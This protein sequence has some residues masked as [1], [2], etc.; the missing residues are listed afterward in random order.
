LFS[1][2]KKKRCL[3][4]KKGTHNPPHSLINVSPSYLKHIF[5]S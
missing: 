5:T 4:E 3:Q 1:H 2:V